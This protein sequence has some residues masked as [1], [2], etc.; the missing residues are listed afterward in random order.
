MNN[1]KDF[2]QYLKEKYFKL[3]KKDKEYLLELDKK[4]PEYGFKSHKGYP[5]KKHLEAIEKY[6][7]VKGSYLSA[8]RIIKCNPFSKGGYDPVP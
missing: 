1:I 3:S 8:K 4:Y 6:G 7:P 2:D 5:T